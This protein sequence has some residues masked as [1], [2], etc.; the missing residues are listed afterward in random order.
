MTYYPLVVCSAQLALNYALAP[1]QH[2]DRDHAD[3]VT[4]TFETLITRAW[5]NDFFRLR[6]GVS[7]MHFGA[8]NEEWHVRGQVEASL[9]APDVALTQLVSVLLEHNHKSTDSHGASESRHNTRQQQLG[10]SRTAAWHCVTAE[11]P[12]AVATTES[13]ATTA[14]AAPAAVRLLQQQ[15][16]QQQRWWHQHSHQHASQPLCCLPRRSPPSS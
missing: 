2:L 11:R 15:Q 9:F 16:Q 4:P 14:A 6:L 7:G 12:P 8:P 13:A 10:S 1:F 5:R 3:H